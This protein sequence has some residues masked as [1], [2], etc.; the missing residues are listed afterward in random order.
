MDTNYP[1]LKKPVAFNSDL[2]VFFF[3]VLLPTNFG[4][5]FNFPSLLL[6]FNSFP[7]LFLHF[8]IHPYL[9][10]FLP[11]IFFFNSFSHSLLPSLSRWWVFNIPLFWWSLYLKLRKYEAFVYKG[12]PMTLWC[13]IQL[14]FCVQNTHWIA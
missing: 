5:F 7:L 6:S 12:Q 9:P 10:L 11:F 3:F 1:M 8:P 4:L 14:E 13:C 2:A